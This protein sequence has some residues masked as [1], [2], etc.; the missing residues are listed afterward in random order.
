MLCK[1]CNI[2]LPDD[3]IYCLKC[4]KLQKR[5]FGGVHL[6][7]SSIPRTEAV[8]YSPA[9]LSSQTVYIDHYSLSLLDLF[10][11]EVPEVRLSD[12]LRI[13]RFDDLDR[14]RTQRLLSED[15]RETLQAVLE[16]DSSLG[17]Y[18]PL[19]YED[20]WGD[21]VRRLRADFTLFALE[22]HAKGNVP[23]PLNKHYDPIAHTG[24]VTNALTS[25]RLLKPDRI[26]RLPA[27]FL[28][29]PIVPAVQ[30]HESFPLPVQG[31]MNIK[32]AP[33]PANQP[34]VGLDVTEGHVHEGQRDDYTLQRR[35]M[36]DA[37][38]LVEEDIA[39]LQSIF[40][41]IQQHASNESLRV[42][43]NRFNRHYSRESAPDKLIDLMI[44]LETL[45]L[46]DNYELK[47]RLALRVSRHI[48]TDHDERIEVRDR[49]YRAYDLRSALVHG[50]DKGASKILSQVG[51][52]GIEEIV[53][54][55]A[56]YLRNGLHNIF[57]SQYVHSFPGAFHK[58]LDRVL[59]TGEDF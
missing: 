1:K 50:N 43:L 9:D 40:K 49:V 59:T 31:V 8:G 4:G 44:G 24:V 58:R 53:D 51:R 22:W 42:A 55:L 30:P 11:S 25:L 57:L 32:D 23:I 47:Y 17:G 27:T 6:T 46:N 52:S 54:D 16:T 56:S 19:D 41:S 21:Q 26:G 13:A 48:R 14:S 34:I 18:I 36:E 45:Y 15:I 38:V 33:R 7:T 12:H 35:P 2:Q 28:G 20:P 5:T 39:P 37:Y 29:L 10:V 3:A